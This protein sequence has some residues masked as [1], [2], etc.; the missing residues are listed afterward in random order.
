[1]VCD[2]RSVVRGS[3][4]YNLTRR[5]RPSRSVI[6][7]TSVYLQD[8]AQ[9]DDESA[10]KPRS[11]AVKLFKAGFRLDL[12]ECCRSNHTGFSQN[13]SLGGCRGIMGNLV[14]FSV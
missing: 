13:F 1:M 11:N 2:R 5:R 8:L 7:F 10:I 4:A 14:T 12:D 3:S 9:R 6:D